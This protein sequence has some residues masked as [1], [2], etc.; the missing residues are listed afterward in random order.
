MATLDGLRVVVTRA[1]HQIEELA[2]PLRTLGAEVIAL[3]LIGIAPP[4]NPEPLRHA[5]S[6]ANSYDW[7]I[8]TS[9]NAVAAFVAVFSGPFKSMTARI[10][11]V[12]SATRVTAEQAG[13]YVDLVPEDYISESLAEALRGEELSGH[14][15]LIPSA[16]ISRD[17]VPVAL[18]QRG[19]TV[20]VVEAYRNVIPPEAAALVPHIFKPPYPDWVTFASSSAVDHLVQIAGAEPLTH[21]KIATIGPATSNTVRKYRLSVKA[22]AKTH[23]VAGLAEALVTGL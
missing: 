11:T 2:G 10:A 1:A 7:I 5:A 21:S 8:F 19:A 14:R 15:I 12:G 18:R 22:E 4:L 20:D 16:A 23:N 3:P 6:Q 17:V 13:F 9:A